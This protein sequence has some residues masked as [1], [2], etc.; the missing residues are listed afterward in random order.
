FSRRRGEV[1]GGDEVV[2][3]GGRGS[4]VNQPDL[5]QVGL[6]KKLARVEVV[7]LDEEVPR[8]VEV[9][10]LVT[11]WTQRLGDGRVGRE[12][13][14]ALARP[15]K[16]VALPGAL[17][18]MTGQFLPQQVEV[19]GPDQAPVG[20]AALGDHAGEQFGDLVEVTLGEGRRVRSQPFHRFSIAQG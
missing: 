10:R 2:A 16:L 14:V 15:V 19:D 9:A 11:G 5:D 13:R 12:A 4:Y 8:A 7:A 6:L 18:H 17:D 20:V 1:V 3:R